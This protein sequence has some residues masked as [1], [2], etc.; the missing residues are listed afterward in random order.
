MEKFLK[1]IVGSDDEEGLKCVIEDFCGR[2][3]YCGE[4]IFEKIFIRF[5]SY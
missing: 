4:Q 1:W 3:F 5:E 2:K